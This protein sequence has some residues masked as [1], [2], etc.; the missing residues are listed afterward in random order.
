MAIQT[1]STP[2]DLQTVVN[3]NAAELATAVETAN[4]PSNGTLRLTKIDIL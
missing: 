2:C 3:N 4:F 1:T